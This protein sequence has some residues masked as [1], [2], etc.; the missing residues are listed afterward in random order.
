MKNKT[1]IVATIGP[2][3]CE[4]DTLRTMSKAGMTVAR[5]NFSHNV[6]EW[7]SDVYNN[8]QD[9]APEVSILQD[10]CGPKIRISLDEDFD[11][12][13]GDIIYLAEKNKRQKPSDIVFNTENIIPLL[14]AGT[15]IMIAD[16]TIKLEII[17]P[18]NNRVESRVIRGGPLKNNK[19]VNIPGVPLPV[20]SITDKDKRDIAWGVEHQADYIALSFVKTAQDVQELRDIIK[21]LNPKKQPKI[22]SKIETVEAIEN[23]ESIV[24]VSDVIMVAR[25]DLGVELELHKVPALQKMIIN[26]CK[27]YGTPAI[28]ATEMV[29]SVCENFVPTRAEVSDVFNAV[30]DGAW[31]VMLSAESATGIDPVNAVHLM[32]QVTREAEDYL[33]NL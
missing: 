22:V 11:V 27:K 14:I 26:V 3:S 17:T 32:R 13:T 33:E 21:S 5:F 18:D 16:G 7:H 19:G 15:H 8:I 1:H 25:G 20:K 10:L 31:G 28:V 12:K 29:Q 4:K 6:H 24:Q 2:K 9:I 30:V 23:I